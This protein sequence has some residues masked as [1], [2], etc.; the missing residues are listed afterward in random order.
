MSAARAPRG[1]V[2]E[3]DRGMRAVARVREVREHD[4]RVGLQRAL[5]EQ[6][7]REQRLAELH[8]HVASA[9]V[10]EAGTASTFLALRTALAALGEATGEAREELAA[11]RRITD[12]A[13]EHWQRDRS[14]LRAVETLLEARAAERAADRA[15][16]EAARLDEAAAQLWLRGADD[17][18]GGAR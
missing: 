8:R 5:G 6:R 9:P 3:D 17:R 18:A 2:H 7:D 11:S 10:F 16:R 1:G 4:S 14:R 15:R 13:R 12:S